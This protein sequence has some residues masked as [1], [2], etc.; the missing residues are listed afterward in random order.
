MMLDFKSQPLPKT[1]KIS[2]N[3]LAAVW[4]TDPA[5][6]RWA[7][8]PYSAPIPPKH[9]GLMVRTVHRSRQHTMGWRSVQCTDPANTRWADG[10]YSAPIP[11]THDGLT[12]RTVHRSRQT[13]DGLT[14]RTVHR[15][16][17][18]TLGW[19]SV[20]C[21]EV[22]NTRWADGPYSAPRPPL[23]W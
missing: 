17:Q 18:N 1:E 7:D 15:S 4:C 5:N 20:Q 16:R 12:V 9:D 22:A 23:K 19:R 8:D 3:A 13:H 10:P 21:T 2:L 6:T 14:V 11:P